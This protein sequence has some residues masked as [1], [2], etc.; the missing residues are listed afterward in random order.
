MLYS[1]HSQLYTQNN[2][3]AVSYSHLQ[4]ENWQDRYHS[5]LYTATNNDR[6]GVILTPAERKLTGQVSLTAVHS[7]KQWQDRCYTDTCRKKTYRTGVTHSCTQQQTMTGQVLYWHLQKENLQDRCHS[8]LYTATKKEEDRT[9]VILTPA[10]RHK[11][12]TR[13]VLDSHLQKKEKTT[14]THR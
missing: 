8:Q 13:Q 2:D 3:R 9:S 7:N 1:H 11:T 6:T 14:T 4:K 10:D 5:Q 12:V